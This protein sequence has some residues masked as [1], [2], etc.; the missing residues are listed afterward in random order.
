MFLSMAAKKS[1]ETKALLEYPMELLDS[2]IQEIR[3]LSQKQV[4]P[5]K[6]LNLKG[7]IQNILVDFSKSTKTASKFDYTADDDTI[8]DEIKLTLYRIVQEQVNN[9]YKHAEA[10]NIWIELSTA[11]NAVNLR[12]TDDGIGFVVNK[13]RKGIGI[14]NMTDRIASFNGTLE[15]KSSPGT[16]CQL[17]ISIPTDNG[18]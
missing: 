12:I 16:G 10:K 15:I 7:M 11:N 1:P 13:K 6:D 9:I 17:N 14:A 18:I 5:L 3:L 8:P 2:S 4:T